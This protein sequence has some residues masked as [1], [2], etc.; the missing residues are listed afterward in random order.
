MKKLLVAALLGLAS[1][2]VN[3]Q[4]VAGGTVGGFGTF[5]D[6]NTNR[7]WLRMDNFFDESADQMLAAAQAQGF[8]FATQADVNQLLGSLPLNGGQWSS[9]AAIMGQAPNRDLIWGAYEGSNPGSVGWAF[10][11]SDYQAWSVIDNVDSSGSIPNEGSPEADL[12]LWAFQTGT[13]SVPEPASWAM[14]VGGFG[15][16]GGALR[17][18]RKATISFA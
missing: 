6:V 8:S 1:T 13:P 3:A 14:M 15:V 17:G 5:V 12:N 10:A 18:R 16:V 4:V 11:Y 7:V 9:Y 2:T